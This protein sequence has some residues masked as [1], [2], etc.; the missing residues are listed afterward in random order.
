[1][2]SN[3]GFTQSNGDRHPVV[4]F[5]GGSGPMLTGRIREAKWSEGRAA[6]ARATALRAWYKPAGLKLLRTGH[7]HHHGDL[8]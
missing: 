7:R 4:A 2:R 3:K 1:M 5:G 6:P 8:G